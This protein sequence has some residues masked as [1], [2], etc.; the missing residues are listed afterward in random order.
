MKVQKIMIWALPICSAALFV[1]GCERNQDMG[2]PPASVERSTGQKVDDKALTS[3]VKDALDDNA[4][5]KFPNVEVNTYGGKVQL[6]GF[7]ATRQQK[8]QAENL[9]KAMAGTTEVENKISVRP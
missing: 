5:Y 6:S 1:T 7:V 2:A 9:A 8:E 3:K 4:A